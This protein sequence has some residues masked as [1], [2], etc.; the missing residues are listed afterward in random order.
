MKLGQIILIV[1]M[2]VAA[3]L[4][5]VHLWGGAPLGKTAEAPGESA[6][7]RVMRTGT[8]R[9]GYLF[10]PKIL[11]RDLN[12]GAYSGY[13]YEFMEEIGKQLSLKIDWAEEMSFASAF[14]GLKTKRYDVAC[15][16]FTLMPGRARVTEFTK[17]I[18][19]LPYFFYV[20]ADDLRFDNA[21][22]KVNDPA[23]KVAILEGELSQLVKAEDYPKAQTVSITSLADINQVLLQIMTGKAD[24]AMTEPSSSEEFMLKNPGKLRRVPGPSL[25]MQPGAFTVAVG[26]DNL[27]ELLNTTIA[28]LQAMGFIERVFKKYATAP[29]QIYMPAPLW[30]DAVKPLE[31]SKP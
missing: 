18:Y 24:V 2:C 15:F 12:T 19:S 5:A 8:I 29:D 26:E 21:Y 14:D 20:R 27:R 13:A 9:C 11:Q 6:Y 1:I 16:P 28:S 4:G 30:G 7:A 23:V 25:R 3:S 22:A 31:E 10:Y 17:P